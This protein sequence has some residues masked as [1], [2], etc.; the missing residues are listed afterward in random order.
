MF[1]RL[2]GVHLIF[3]ARQSPEMFVCIL[4]KTVR[5]HL[6]LLPGAGIA[7]ALRHPSPVEIYQHLSKCLIVPACPTCSQAPSLQSR[8]WRQKWH[9]SRPGFRRIIQRYILSQSRNMFYQYLVWVTRPAQR[10]NS[11][12]TWSPAWIYQGPG[13]ISTIC[14]A[15]YYRK[16]AIHLGPIRISVEWSN[17]PLAVTRWYS[18]PS[19]SVVLKRYLL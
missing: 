13:S 19:H 8:G 12:S 16:E 14:L 1:A 3:P 6:T 18:I 7:Q 9:C 17:F 2:Y 15:F 11:P 10:N 5:P 4:Y